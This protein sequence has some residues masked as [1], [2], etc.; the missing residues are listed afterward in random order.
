[1]IGFDPGQ[2]GGDSLTPQ[3]ATPVDIKLSLKKQRT[4][5]KAELGPADE[6]RGS[7][8]AKSPLL[9]QILERA[10]RPSSAQVPESAGTQVPRG[11]QSVRSRQVTMSDT[12]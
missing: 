3:Q 11:S 8:R 12:Q 9:I 2:H 7:A 1:M 5:L 6:R 4:E 10:H